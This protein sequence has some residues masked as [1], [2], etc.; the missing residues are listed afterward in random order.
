M[1][2]D[3]DMKPASALEVTLSHLLEKSLSR[4]ILFHLYDVPC[5]EALQQK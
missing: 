3:T 1:N 2:V 5:W 4:S